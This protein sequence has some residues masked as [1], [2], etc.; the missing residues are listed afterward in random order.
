MPELEYMDVSRARFR[1]TAGGLVSLELD[2]T[3]YPKVDVY[4]SR[5]LTLGAVYLHSR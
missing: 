1:T 2:D 3:F 5:F 4:L